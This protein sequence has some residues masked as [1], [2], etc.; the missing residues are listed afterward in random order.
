MKP[1]VTAIANT[2]AKPGV[3]CHTFASRNQ[4]TCADPGVGSVLMSDEAS[5]RRLK[6]PIRLK[7]MSQAASVRTLCAQ[8]LICSLSKTVFSQTQRKLLQR[9]LAVCNQR[10]VPQRLMNFQQLGV[11]HHGKK[12]LTGLFSGGQTKLE[13]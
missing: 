3:L 12:R 4:R 10:H 13:T 5:R 2:C 7:L 8:S 9:A 11:D 1:L 6:L